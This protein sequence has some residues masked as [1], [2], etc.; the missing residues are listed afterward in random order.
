MRLLLLR[1]LCDSCERRRSNLVTAAMC[2]GRLVEC[3]CSTLFQRL[4][5]DSTWCSV[6]T[7]WFWLLAPAVD[8][9]IYRAKQ[10]PGADGADDGGGGWPWRS[11]RLFVSGLAVVR[12]THPP[13][14]PPMHHPPMHRPPNP[15]WSLRTAV[16]L[17]EAPRLSAHVADPI[18][19]CQSL[20]CH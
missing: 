19:H 16:L 20:A 11:S 15:A 18:A 17:R 1:L 5:S 2:E 13:T 12:S 4:A 10:I 6:S 3:L 8:W 9:E 14:H 7:C